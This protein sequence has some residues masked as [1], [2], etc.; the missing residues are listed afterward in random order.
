MAR[1]QT[2]SDIFNAI[3]EQDRRRIIGLLVREEMTVNE[4]VNELQFTQPTVSKHLRVLKEVNVVTVRKEGQHRYYSLHPDAMK[5]IYDWIAP[6]QVFWSES[7]DRLDN[8]FKERK[9]DES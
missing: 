3:G 2:T 1:A 7:F 4:I 5:P 6:F 9:K 8:Y